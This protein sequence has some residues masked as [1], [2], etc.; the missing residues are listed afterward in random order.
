MINK[1]ADNE[2]NMNAKIFGKPVLHYAVNKG[3]VESTVALI[4]N[5]ANPNLTDK[6]GNTALHRASYLKD[7]NKM[8]RALVEGGADINVQNNL[9]MSP[10]YAL[11]ALNNWEEIEFLIDNGA[12]INIESSGGT[13]LT[14]AIIT[15]NIEVINLLLKQDIT[16]DAFD[17]KLAMEKPLLITQKPYEIFHLIFDKHIS[18]LKKEGPIDW[19]KGWETVR[20]F[21]KA[22]PLYEKN[23]FLLTIAVWENRLEAV[24]LFLDHRVGDSDFLSGLLNFAL[25]KDNEEMILLLIKNGAEVGS[26]IIRTA[27]A[28]YKREEKVLEFLKNKTDVDAKIIN[29][30]EEHYKSKK[31]RLYFLA[32]ASL[33]NSKVLTPAIESGDLEEIKLF[34]EHKPQSKLYPYILFTAIYH[35]QPAIVELLIEEKLVDINAPDQEGHVPIESA[36]MKNHAEIVKLLIDKGAIIDDWTYILAKGSSKEILHAVI[37]KIVVDSRALGPEIQNSSTEEVKAFIENNPLYENHQILFINAIWYNKLEVIKLFTERQLV[38]LNSPDQLGWIPMEIAVIKGDEKMISFLIDN[39]AKVNKS[40]MKI[41]QEQNQL[42]NI[43]KL[44]TQRKR[45]KRQNLCKDAF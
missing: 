1:L 31:D 35:N 19:E 40:I 27:K 22:N 32:E 13:A 24:Q 36:I 6:L 33:Y 28:Q 41:A 42:E 7:K 37:D 14:V 11:S 44:L 34:I 2:A 15:G 12:D 4:D 38:D 3:F 30:A 16:I 20:S 5:G 18:N 43:N 29:K 10:I 26:S 45:P 25:I 8:I 23:H 17:M 21:I 9:G 39:G